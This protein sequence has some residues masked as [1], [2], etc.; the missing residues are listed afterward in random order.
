MFVIVKLF[1]LIFPTIISFPF[2]FVN[3]VLLSARLFGFRSDDQ[4]A[5]IREK[6]GAV[7][8]FSIFMLETPS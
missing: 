5:V 4:G 6:E 7:D 8:N 1:G 3:E 2:G